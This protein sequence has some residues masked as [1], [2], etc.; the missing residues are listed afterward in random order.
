VVQ[1]GNVGQGKVRFGLEVRVL[2]GVIGSGMMR[3]TGVWYDQFR[4][5]V[6][7]WGD[8]RQG[9][10]YLEVRV[11]SGGVRSDKVRWGMIR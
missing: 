4:R 7:W 5:G 2:Y 9:K 6:I 3:P 10:D 1:R 8:V 11:V